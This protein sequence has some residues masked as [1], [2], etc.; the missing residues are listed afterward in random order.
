M[1]Q[2]SLGIWLKFKIFM[3]KLKKRFLYI[4]TKNKVLTE[5]TSRWIT[6]DFKQKIGSFEGNMQG[7]FE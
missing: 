4:Q 2:W 5:N 1:S 6:W 3:L 7:E